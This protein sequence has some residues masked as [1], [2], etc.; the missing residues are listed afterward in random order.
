M[1]PET[2]TGTKS[3][4]KNQALKLAYGSIKRDHSR[5]LGL[6]EA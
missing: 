4:G 1:R 3:I 6:T 2:S 5:E